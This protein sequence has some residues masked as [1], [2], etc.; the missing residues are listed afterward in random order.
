MGNKI[1][2][3]SGGMGCGGAERVIS[4]LANHYAEQGWKVGIVL[5]LCSE[6]A[7]PLN[8]KITIFQKSITTPN[9]MVIFIIH[10]LL[11]LKRLSF[12][13]CQYRAP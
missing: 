1:L 6:V 9:G 5:M 13:Q 8:E 11:Y 12:R 4:I 10:L 7:Y 3:V 2:F